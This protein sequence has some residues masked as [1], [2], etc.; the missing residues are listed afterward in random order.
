MRLFAVS[1]LVIFSCLLAFSFSVYS[2]ECSQVIANYHSQGYQDPASC[3][4]SC[5]SYVWQYNAFTVAYKQYLQSTSFVGCSVS[6]APSGTSVCSSSGSTGCIDKGSGVYIPP[7]PPPPPS[8]PLCSTLVCADVDQQCDNG[9]GTPG[10]KAACP[11]NPDPGTG[12]SGGGGTTPPPD[13][14]LP[15]CSTLICSDID[16]SCLNGDGTPGTKAACPLNPDPGIGGSGG[17][18]TG[19]GTTPP[20]DCPAQDPNSHNEAPDSCACNAGYHYDVGT[21]GGN[22][23]VDTPAT[24]GTGG[25]GGDTGGTTPPPVDP[26]TGGTGGTG[27]TGG[28][29]GTIPGDTGGSSGGGGTGG[30]SSGSGGS[31]GSGGS[32][33]GSVPDGIKPDGSPCQTTSQSADPCT[34]VSTCSGIP[35]PAICYNPDCPAGQYDTMPDVPGAQCGVIPPP[36]DPPPTDPPATPPPADPPP[37][38]PPATP[39]PTDPPANPPPADPPPTDPPANPPPADPPPD[40][41]PNPVPNFGTGQGS[42]V[43]TLSAC[44]ANSTDIHCAPSVSQTLTDLKGAFTGSP[45]ETTLNTTKAKVAALLGS[46]TASDCPVIMIPMDYFGKPAYAMTSH[47]TIAEKLRPFVKAVTTVAWSLFGLFIFLGA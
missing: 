3:A 28:S 26:G 24:G 22:C 17:G 12:G 5:Y 14:I 25:T 2:T 27:D 32:G 36:P 47:C 43:P 6:A 11:L 31:T 46:S 44:N 8:L 41:L 39:P 10:T 23:V 29:G 18:G 37:T 40:P 9:D 45:M 15:Q 20:L 13:P 21:P 30:G 35:H 42:F 19:G 7:P 16:Q 33:G 1:R 4:P 34:P 38:D